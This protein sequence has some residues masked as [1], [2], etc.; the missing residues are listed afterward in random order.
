MEDEASG[1]EDVEVTAVEAR[2][3]RGKENAKQPQ[4]RRVE[5]LSHPETSRQQRLMFNLWTLIS[6]SHGPPLLPLILLV[7]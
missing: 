2:P 5:P 3:G 1:S 6:C 7:R 4:A